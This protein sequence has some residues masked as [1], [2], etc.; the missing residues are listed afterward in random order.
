M[1][2]PQPPLPG[3]PPEPVAALAVKVLFTTV[4]SPLR[5]PTAPPLLAE[6]PLKVEPTMTV[7]PPPKP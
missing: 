6:L 1:A 4:R 2:P 5:L 3:L 7:S